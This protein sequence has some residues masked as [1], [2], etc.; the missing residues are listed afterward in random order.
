MFF[1][2]AQKIALKYVQLILT[3][4]CQSF[5]TKYQ[6]ELDMLIKLTYHNMK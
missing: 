4:G 1:L 5:N 3:Q 2:L 6:H